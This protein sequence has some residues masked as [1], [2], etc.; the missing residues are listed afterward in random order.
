MATASVG[1][2]GGGSFWNYDRGNMRYTAYE[3]MTLVSTVAPAVGI[4][5]NSWLMV[6]GTVNI[7]A[8][9]KMTNFSKLGDGYIGDA[10]QD[11]IRGMLAGTVPD[12]IIDG[13]INV[14]PLSTRDGVDD[15]KL[16]LWTDKEFPTGLQPTNSMDIDF[17]HLSFILG[18]MA[19][20]TDRL[21]IGATYRGATY[22]KY[23]GQAEIVIEETALASVNWLLDPLGQ[24]LKNE[25]TRFRVDVVLPRT[26]VLGVA[27][28]IT[29]WCLL[30]SDLQWTNWADAWKHQA[31]YLEGNGLLGM[32][33][34]IQ[35][36]WYMDTFS[37]RLGAEFT[38]WKGLRVQAGYWL[39]PTPVP[40]ST[41]DATTADS[42]KPTTRPN[43][44]NKTDQQGK[45]LTRLPI[46]RTTWKILTAPAVR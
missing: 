21:T 27:Y 46:M 40:D 32:T 30:A 41:F 2:A 1:H 4:K 24:G 14:L 44:Q 18:V 9:N 8:L 33:T 26:A 37:W 42:D 39:D 11:N 22:F 15:G 3:T 38:P 25:S 5:L 7:V 19:K 36:R 13:L 6:G 29:D 35:N 28:Q 31:T 45:S 34:I 17:R 16:G 23:E 20:V 43:V 12:P 10:V